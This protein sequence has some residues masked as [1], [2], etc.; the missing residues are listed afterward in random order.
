[1]LVSIEQLALG[2][3]TK[4]WFVAFADFHD[5]HTAAMADFKVPTCQWALL[6]RVMKD[7][8]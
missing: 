7:A 3:E 1:M 4:S 5:V 8:Q 6:E 2:E